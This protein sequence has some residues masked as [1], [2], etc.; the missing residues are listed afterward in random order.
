MKPSLIRSGDHEYVPQIAGGTAA[1]L[2]SPRA[3]AHRSLRSAPRTGRA[4]VA[5]MN[6]TAP[7]GTMTAVHAAAYSCFEAEQEPGVV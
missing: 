1:A 5:G 7:R 6:E 2:W 4:I 3:A